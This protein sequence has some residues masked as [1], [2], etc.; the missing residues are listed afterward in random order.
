M[1]LDTLIR[2]LEEILVAW[3]PEEAQVNSKHHFETK[4]RATASI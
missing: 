4:S 3:F 1:W 2:L